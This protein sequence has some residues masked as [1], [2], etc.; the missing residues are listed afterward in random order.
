MA[1]FR[2][3][4]ADRPQRYRLPAESKQCCRVSGAST[5]SSRTRSPPKRRV[6]P[7][8]ISGLPASICAGR[9]KTNVGE[10]STAVNR[11]GKR[12]FT[13]FRVFLQKFLYPANLGWIHSHGDLEAS[14]HF[15]V[16]G[17][18]LRLGQ[19][20]ATISVCLFPPVRHDA[21]VEQCQIS[22]APHWHIGVDIM[23]YR[24]LPSLIL[25]DLAPAPDRASQKTQDVGRR[26]AGELVACSAFPR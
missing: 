17:R 3:S 24:K 11:R 16:V 19:I 13:G 5:P 21:V 14:L 7:S 26:P 10:G 1:S 12:P 8:S 6:S 15:S 9:L 23:E 25:R 2:A 20:Q 18:C 22:Q 4:F